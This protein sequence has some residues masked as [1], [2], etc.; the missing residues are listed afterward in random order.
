MS[1]DLVKAEVIAVRALKQ[2]V[3][4]YAEQIREASGHARREIAAANRKA[5]EAV[6]RR[7]SEVQKREQEL[8]QA[9]AALRQCQENCDRLQ[10]QVKV[11]A[12]RLAEAK[13]L[14]DRARK[15]AQLTATA[16]SDLLKVLQNIEATIGEHSSV[17]S[18]ALA[19][20]DAKLAELPHFGVGHAIHNLA[21]DTAIGMEIVGATMSLGRVAGD[22][23]QAASVDFPIRDQSI[24][25]MVEHRKDQERDYVIEQDFESKKRMNSG[26]GLETKP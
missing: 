21:V 9:E 24:T 12:Q 25:E 3:A 13:Q 23:L 14:L 11:A 17:A 20:L 7:R 8:R 4:R 2:G 1:D 10:Q 19:S 26:E 22:A 16:Q 6:E 18:S 15:A 5:E